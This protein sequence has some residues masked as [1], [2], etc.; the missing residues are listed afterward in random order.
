M[1]RLLSRL[2]RKQIAGKVCLLRVDLNIEAGQERNSFRVGAIVP[3]VRY[4]RRCGA[5]V[6]LLSHRG[7][8]ARLNRADSLHPFAAT[9]EKQLRE[10][11][12][13]IPHFT[14][15]KLKRQLST[16]RGG[17]WLLENIRFLPGEDRNDLQLARRL[18][19]LGDF[20]VNDAFAVSHRRN[21][22]VVA[23]TR[24]LPSYGGLL[25]ES[26]LENLNRVMKRYRRPLTVVIGGAKI[27]DKLGVI[28]YF[29]RKADRF[30]LAGGPANTFFAAKGLPVGDSLVDRA[31]I[32]SIKRYLKS[33][34]I[35]LP[36]D[37]SVYHR[38]I[39]DIGERTIKEWGD[40]LARSRTIIWNGP[41]GLFEKKGFQQ[42]TRAIWHMLLANRKAQI[43]IGG[44]ETTAS[45]RL[46][47]KPHTL[48]AKHPNLF[49]S[50]GGGAMLEYLSGKKLPGIEIL[51]H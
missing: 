2:D 12:V 22:S 37:V 30:L 44:G 20:Y 7:R 24:Y 9:L 39:L 29:W 1:I 8:P 41:P 47:A 4:L 25:L 10:P 45:L 33:P 16:R 49:I 19:R 51:E 3:T 26:E 13:F 38:Q 50:T 11:V 18:A 34:K 28:T 17:V 32:P 23:I 35:I 14:F 46:L 42:G 43:I 48:M 5:S 27:A 31:A 36:S 6:V 40:V 15:G 21:A